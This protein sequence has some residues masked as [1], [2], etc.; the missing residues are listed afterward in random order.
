MSNEMKNKHKYNTVG[1]ILK[2]NTVGT[3]LKSNIKIV[4]RDKIDTPGTHIHNRSLSQL[5][6]NIRRA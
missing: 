2:Y 5:E 1:T 3:I 4:E 6:R